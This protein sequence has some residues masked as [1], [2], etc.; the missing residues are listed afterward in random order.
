MRYKEKK[1]YTRNPKQALN[2]ILTD[3][4]VLDIDNFLHPSS[5]CELEPTRLENLDA[6]ARMLMKHLESNSNI[7]FIVDC[8]VDGYTS[9][10]ILWLYIKELYPDINLDFM[11]HDHKQHGL[12]DV[13]HKI[14]DNNFNLVICPDSASYD[15]EEHWTLNNMGMDCLVID[16]HE[17][18]NDDNGK[19]IVSDAPRTV[20]INNQLS[21]NYPNKSL[22]GAG[23]VYKFCEYLDS[24]IGVNNAFKFIDLVALGEIADVMNRANTETNYLMMEGLKHI[25]NK[26]FASLLMAQS[27][28]LKDKGVP[29]FN[30]LTTIDIA[31]YIAPLINAITRVGTKT[32]KEILFKCFVLPDELVQS[33]KRGA[34]AGEYET[35][36][37][38][39]ARVGKNAKSR[40]DRI[41]EKAMETV[42]F[43]IEKEGLNNDNIILVEV[44]AD[45]DIP[46]ELTGLVAMGMVNKYHRPV[47]IGRRNDN[48]LI[49]GSI[50]S[51][52]NFA[53]IPSFKQFLENSKFIE[54]TAGHD[55]AAGFGISGSKVDQFIK[56]AN[57]TLRAED[58]DNCYLVDYILNADDDN[59]DLL[60]ELGS[61]SQYFGN[62]VEEITLVVENITYNNFM[63]M[64]ANK[65]SVKISYNNMDYIKFKDEDFINELE[66]N[67]NKKLVIYGRPNVN[68][69]AGKTTIQCIISDYQF[70]D[71]PN[72][73]DF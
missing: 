57:T 55:N 67:K 56:F 49:Q 27:Y 69:F 2:D 68:E 45:D 12:S 37:E 65:D 16:H 9:S 47:M 48:D 4:G 1:H 19:P 7:L 43:K 24:I 33:T 42:S 38:Q 17:Q 20:I 63:R 36:A 28:S 15:V 23:V 14:E 70:V 50:R 73:Y 54:Y 6:G 64:G 60:I 46:Q 10:S 53:G 40:Q 29:P 5:A 71:D 61:H 22:C 25:R 58:F 26:G 52:N 32:E 44:D 35:A 18:Q 39:T 13:V 8:D 72:K 51:N 66:E 34:K 31:F 11:V 62:Q 3:R 41:K 21:P 30:G 59:Y